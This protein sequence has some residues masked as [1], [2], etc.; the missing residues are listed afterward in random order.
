MAS[1]KRLGRIGGVT[2]IY[3]SIA[4]RDRP[5]LRYTLRPM[6]VGR[7]YL[8]PIPSTPA[9]QAKNIIAIAGCH[10]TSLRLQWPLQSFYMSW[11]SAILLQASTCRLDEK[12]SG[13]L[14]VRL[15]RSWVHNSPRF[16]RPFDPRVQVGLHY[17]AATRTKQVRIELSRL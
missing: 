14:S 7:W 1:S 3:K 15:S 5:I 9:H 2:I 8:Q 12:F 4:T 6:I 11:T 10:C 17:R 13:R 16:C